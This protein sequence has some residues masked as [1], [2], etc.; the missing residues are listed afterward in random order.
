MK[1][2]QLINYRNELDKMS[3]EPVRRQVDL[4]LESINHLVAS[5]EP[6]IGTY[7]QT[8]GLK[9]QN[10]LNHI[11][12]FE[13]CFVELKQQVSALI[14]QLEKPA[15]QESYR[16]YEEEMCGETVEY[17]LD[18]R[19]NITDQTINMF[20]AR[21][22]NYSNWQHPGIIIRPGREPWINDLVSFDPLYVIDEDYDLLK[23]CLENFPEVYQR[24]V[25]C[26]VTNERKDNPILHKIPDSQ[27]AM[28]LVY[29]FFNFRPLEVIKQ[30]LAE[31]Y[32]KLKPGGMLIMTFNDCDRWQAVDLVER[33]FA[34][35][36]PGTLI[37]QLSE[38]I[39]YEQ[40]FSWNDGGPS[41]WLELKKPGVLTSLKGGQTLAKIQSK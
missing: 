3:A 13:Q 21:I 37:R 30:Y 26:Y 12:E 32:Q 20:K 6:Q 4:Q 16:L 14:E 10:V 27:F 7:T 2:S 11:T 33:S 18:R 34:C 23:P 38:S 25:R 22:S 41:T 9:K 36:T 35:Y 24:R 17:I 39:G 1:L 8:L 5:T 28:C 31:I 40:V 15:F 19:P 29:N